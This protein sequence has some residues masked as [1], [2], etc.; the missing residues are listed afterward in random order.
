M[1][2]L[3]LISIFPCLLQ[4][5]PSVNLTVD[6]APHPGTA[7]TSYT[8]RFRQKLFTVSRRFNSLLPSFLSG[9]KHEQR[10]E[11]YKQSMNGSEESGIGYRKIHLT[12]VFFAR[13]FTL[14]RT[15]FITIFPTAFYDRSRMTGRYLIPLKNRTHFCRI[16]T[17]PVGRVWRFIH[18]YSV[19]VLLEKWFACHH[20][21]PYFFI[22]VFPTAFYDRSR[23]TGRYLMPLCKSHFFRVYSHLPLSS[24]C[25]LTPSPTSGDGL[26]L[27]FFSFVATSIQYCL[28]NAIHPCRHS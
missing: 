6:T 28:Q 4:L 27:L 2:I 3:I 10:T 1:I 9:G 26:R 24:T 18:F 8:F 14:P 20:S 19:A 25:R 15:F 16:L 23:M 5:A 13:F 22:I 17:D 7:Y 21:F 11:I 12:P